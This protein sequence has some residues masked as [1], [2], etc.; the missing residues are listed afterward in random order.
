[1][2]LCRRLEEAIF[3]FKIKNVSVSQG[4]LGTPGPMG[5]PGAPGRGLPGQKVSF[6]AFQ[7]ICCP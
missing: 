3:G 2:N 5:A 7:D 6:Y 1:M 4:E